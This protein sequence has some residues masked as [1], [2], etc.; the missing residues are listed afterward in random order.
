VLAGK[1]AVISGAASPR[2]I[3]FAT[4]RLF[5]QHGAR[6]AILDIDAAGAT[7]AAHEVGD[8]HVG[9][10]CTVAERDS[11]QAAAHQVLEAF[12][13]VDILTNNAGITRPVKTMDITEAVRH[14]IVDVNMTGVLFLRQAFIPAMRERKRGSIACI[15]SVSAQRGGGIFGGPHYSAAKAGVLGLT[16]AMARELGPVISSGFMTIRAL[17]VATRLEADRGNVA[18]LHVATIKPLD[19]ATILRKAGRTGR[20]VVAAKNH[21]VIGGLGE[22][23]AT[24]LMREGVYPPLFRQVALP[25]AFLD[26]G[27]LPTLNDRYGISASAMSTSIKG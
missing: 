5:V 18:V 21:S 27:A 16:K 17:E 14:R 9:I 13:T 1:S 23:V 6:V 26:A 20:I 15:S 19:T 12:G 4:A 2:G 7:R 11:C 8:G 25:N 22:A 10:G 3:G 24:L